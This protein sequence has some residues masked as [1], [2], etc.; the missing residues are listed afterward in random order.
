MPKS[1]LQK[2][3]LVKVYRQALDNAK[4]A[5]I[6]ANKGLTVVQTEAIREKFFANQEQF[7][8]IKNS[9]FKIALKQQG[10]E[11]PAEL[12]DRPLALAVSDSDEVL[13]AKDITSFAKDFDT[14]EVVAGVYE[15]AAVERSVVSKL[16]ALPAKEEL[17]AKVVMT[18]KAPLT[19]L[20]NVL[21]G[22]SRGLVNVL[23]QIKEQKTT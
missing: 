11:L 2:S 7:L 23:S 22:P 14:I 19:G 6:V 21:R 9:L 18:I 5:V 10:L 12:F 15:K 20:V 16:A 4:M 13:V 8:I 17:I 3:E 1:R